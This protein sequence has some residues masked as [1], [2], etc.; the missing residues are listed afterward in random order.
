MLRQRLAALQAAAS[1]D[2]GA[3]A[4]AS[5][6]FRNLVREIERVR[7]IADSAA[8]SIGTGSGRSTARVPATKAEAFDLLGLNPDVAK[9]TLKKVADGLRMS[10]HPDLA[11]DD[12]DRTQ[13]EARIKAINIAID[14][15]NGKRVAA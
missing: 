2:E 5:P 4:R 9:G 10:W 11:R 15:I 14:L 12:D 8:I 7:R 3:A 1:E 6:G 13:R